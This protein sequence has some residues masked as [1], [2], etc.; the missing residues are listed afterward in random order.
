MSVPRPMT[1]TVSSLKQQ[2]QQLQEMHDSGALSKAKY[3]DSRIVLERRLV[4]QVMRG[5]GPAAAEGSHGA[6]L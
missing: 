1:E 3:E 4:E 6:E 5:E 2:L